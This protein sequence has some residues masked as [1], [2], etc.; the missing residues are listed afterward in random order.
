MM[1]MRRGAATRLAVVFDIPSGGIWARSTYQAQRPQSI[2][3]CTRFSVHYSLYTKVSSSV[4]VTFLLLSLLVNTPSR[5][6]RR[7]KIL[8]VLLIS[9]STSLTQF[10]RQCF[11]DKKQINTS[12]VLHSLY[13]MEMGSFIR[14]SSCCHPR[15]HTIRITYVNVCQWFHP[16]LVRQ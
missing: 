6:L 13:N 14:S 11:A 12:Y 3:K 2:N 15:E 5:P 16:R 7:L 1:M 8:H 9:I 4:I 10:S